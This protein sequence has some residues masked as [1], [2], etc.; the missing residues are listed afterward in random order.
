MLERLLA[1]RHISH[2]DLSPVR[3]KPVETMGWTSEKAER[4][5]LDY[6]RFLYALVRKDSEDIISPP[7]AEVDEFW[8]QH[9]LDTRKYRE[10]CNKVFGHYVDHMPGFELAEQTKADERR[11]QVYRDHDIDS[12]W[13]DSGDGGSVDY[14]FGNADEPRHSHGHSHASHAADG[15]HHGG[16]EGSGHG[17]DG[18]GGDGG[19]M[20]AAIAVLVETGVAV[21]MGVAAVAVAEVVVAAAKAVMAA[22]TGELSIKSMSLGQSSFQRWLP[23]IAV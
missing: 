5:E 13:F 9:I 10:D 12:L 15:S 2:L 20:R 8:H 7:T 16:A 6:R 14:S 1:K 22:N 4:V 23:A 18:H 3:R 19:G 11:R 17:D 21:A